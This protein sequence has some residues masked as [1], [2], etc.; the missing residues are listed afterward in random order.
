VFRTLLAVERASCRFADHVIVANHLWHEKLISRTVPARK[1]TTVMNYPD[2]GLFKP[3]AASEQRRDGTFLILYPGTLN[4]HQGV[5]IAIRAFALACDRM[6]GAELHI[7]GEGP[8]R[9]ELERLAREL[10]V[11]GRVKVK[12]RVPIN[13]VSTLMASADLGV[14]PKR[15][16]GFGNEAFSTKILEFMACGVPVIVSRTQVD[17]YYFDDSVV[18]FF[19]SGDAGDLAEA[20]VWAFE[21]RLEHD[22]WIRSARDFAVRYSWQERVVDYKA[23]VEALVRPSAAAEALA[24]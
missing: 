12:D 19:T 23:I 6:P 16:E 11:H 24:G 13:E 17:S 10:P 20:L 9:P 8:A 4:Q 14:V 7:Y 21:H 18:R 22:T 15:A 2:L 5:D 3:L 1:C